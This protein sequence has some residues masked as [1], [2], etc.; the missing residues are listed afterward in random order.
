MTISDEINK[1]P[2]YSLL[3]T[4]ESF[5]VNGAAQN[6]SPSLI[7]GTPP[8]SSMPAIVSVIVSISNYEKRRY[9]SMA[10]ILYLYGC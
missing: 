5:D 1:L 4:L 8:S 6:V 3:L 2:I 9:A 7:L 10:V